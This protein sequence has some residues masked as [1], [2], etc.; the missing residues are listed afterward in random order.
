[1]K[2][3]TQRKCYNPDIALKRVGELLDKMGQ[4]VLVAGSWFC[5]GPRWDTMHMMV[6]SADKP[7]SETAKPSIYAHEIMCSAV[8]SLSIIDTKL[9]EGGAR[10]AVKYTRDT[11]LEWTALKHS[12]VR[13][14]QSKRSR[15]VAARGNPLRAALDTAI[16]Q[17]TAS[18]H[19]HRAQQEMQQ[20]LQARGATTEQ[21]MQAQQQAALAQGVSIPALILS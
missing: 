9:I 18:H 20:Y 19:G 17:W 5:I 21:I 1:M 15:E 3:S 11:C 7:G 10:E 12:Q 2:G 4:T 16:D 14:R 6:V 8:G 13:A